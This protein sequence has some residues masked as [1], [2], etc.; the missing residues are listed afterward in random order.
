[1]NNKKKYRIALAIMT[2]GLEYEDRV[3][4]EIGSI[5]TL[6]PNLEFKIFAALPNNKEYEGVTSFGVPFKSVFVPSREKYASGT[7]TMYKAY[8][9]YRVIKKELRDF[10]AVW[11]GDYHTVVIALLCRNKPVLWDLHELPSMLLGNSV[12]RMMLRK[13]FANC[14]VI[15]HA[16]TQRIVYLQRQGCI[17]YPEKHI[18]LR[19][20]P[21][22]ED[23]DSDYDD[24]YKSFVEWKGNRDCVYLQGLNDSSRADK[25]SI[26]A[27]LSIP[28]LVAAVVGRFSEDTK[29]E[30]ERKWGKEVLS[31]RVFFVGKLPQLKIPQYVAMCITSL[32]FYK[33]VRPNNYY[34]EANRFYQAV[35][36]G[37]PVV[38][39]N[40]PS[41][42]EL[43]ERYGFGLSIEDDG[44]DIE[45]IKDGITEVIAHYD[46]FC[47]NI[48]N[49]RGR[50]IWNGQKEEV[51]CIVETL[52]K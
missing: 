13:V 29:K 19:N 12:K 9:F 3:R 32:V 14:K 34:C 44:E 37:L 51:R 30:L 7:K 24:K 46:E 35:I 10:D 39:G 20:Y 11:C 48:S 1:M 16:N 22:F 21:N 33:N 36:S 41:M 4:K 42:K 50:L 17:K 40:N 45:K 52:F 8:D 47:K 2:N 18:A 23:I 25:E 6:Y 49:N 38:T 5:S 31:N 27:V 26:E 28:N 43:V 15:V